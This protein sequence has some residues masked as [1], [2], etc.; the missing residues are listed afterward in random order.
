[1]TQEIKPETVAQVPADELLQL[2]IAHSGTLVFWKGTDLRYQGCN[3]A[4]AEA[5]GLTSPFDLIGK[6]DLEL[7]ADAELAHAYAETDR[8]VMASDLP[9]TSYDFA[10]VNT[11]GDSQYWVRTYKFPVR[12]VEG[13]VVGVLGIVRDDY[14]TDLMLQ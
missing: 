5:V 9:Y 11:R 6:N 12:N 4:F 8:E 7:T 1:M 10:R 2:V 3:Q 14:E 13:C